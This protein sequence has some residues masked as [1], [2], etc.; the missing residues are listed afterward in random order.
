MF[1]WIAIVGSCLFVTLV[2]I[3]LFN[4][5]KWDIYDVLRI[6]N[7][8]TL[9]V[10]W[11]LRDLTEKTVIKQYGQYDRLTDQLQQLVQKLYRECD[12]CEYNFTE[13]A[14]YWAHCAKHRYCFDCYEEQSWIVYDKNGH[15]CKIN[16]CVECNTKQKK[17]LKI[18][19]FNSVCKFMDPNKY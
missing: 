2:T 19:N 18:K 7:E 5:L 16:K 6:V 9:S 10:E 1:Y 11:K 15:F 3:I 13:Q 12:G 17:R 4:T 8:R 14:L